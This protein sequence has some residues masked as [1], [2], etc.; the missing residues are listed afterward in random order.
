MNISG[1]IVCSNDVTDPSAE[2]VLVTTGLLE[3]GAPDEAYYNLIFSLNSSVDCIFEMGVY[4]GD[5]TVNKVFKRN[6]PANTGATI[7]LQKVSIVDGQ[8]VQ[9]VSPNSITG[10]VNCAI[11]SVLIAED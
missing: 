11:N 6:V 1:D 9:V 3:S 5:G 4:N 7:S 8:Q 2:A 10:V